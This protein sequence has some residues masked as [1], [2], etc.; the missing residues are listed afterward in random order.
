M[1]RRIFAFGCSFTEYTWPT[2]ADMIL[3]NNEGVNYG[4]CGGGFENILNNLVQC[5]FDYKLT[6]E[7]VIVIVY[8][9]L[10]RWDCAIYPKTKGFGN[11]MTS[12]WAEYKEELWNIDGMVYKNLNI[13]IMIDT[14]LKSKGVIYRYSSITKIFTYLENY[15]VDCQVDNSVLNHLNIVKDKIPLLQDFYTFLYGENTDDSKW[16]VTKKWNGD[17]YEYHPRPISHYKWLTNI[18]LPTLD[19]EVNLNTNNIDFM[20]NII[21]KNDDFNSV[22]EYFIHSKYIQNRKDWYKQN[23]KLI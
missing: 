9:N 19:V 20:E 21:N 13:M 12:P 18:L 16:E 7:D 22:E 1:K 14:F 6:P 8:P 10:L 2:W 4:I 17:R 5:D 11:A 23:K 3:Y 15:F